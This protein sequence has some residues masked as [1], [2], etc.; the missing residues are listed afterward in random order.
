MA[1]KLGDFSNTDFERLFETLAD[2]EAQLKAQDI[3]FEAL[4]TEEGCTERPEVSP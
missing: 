3:D 4:S 2:W 1:E